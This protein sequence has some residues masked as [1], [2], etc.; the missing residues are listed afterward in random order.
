MKLRVYFL[1]NKHKKQTFTLT[2]QEKK[3]EG[4]SKI[5]KKRGEITTNIK[6]IQRIIRDYD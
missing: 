4:S 6:D 2:Y 5:R 1:K 3:R